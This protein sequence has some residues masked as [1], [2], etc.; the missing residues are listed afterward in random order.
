MEVNFI[1]VGQSKVTI[2]FEIY[3]YAQ[4]CTILFSIIKV[5][6]SLLYLVN[7]VQLVR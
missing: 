1:Q 6:Q 5:I 4:K 7:L 3:L 2:P